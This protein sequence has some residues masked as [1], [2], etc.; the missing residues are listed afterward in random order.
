MRNL[1]VLFLVTVVVT[2]AVANSINMEREDPLTPP[3]ERED[4]ATPPME[5]EDPATPPMEREDPVTPPMEVESDGQMKLDDPLTPPPPSDEDESEAA[6]PDW[7]SWAGA[8]EGDMM[9]T[10]EQMRQ[11]NDSSAERN[12]I[13]GTRY[14]WPNGVIPYKFDSTTFSTTDKAKIAQ[15]FAK[16]AA[17]TCLRMVP[18][19][20]QSNYVSIIRDSGC[21]SYVGRIGGGQKLSLGYGCV[22]ERIIIHEFM[23]AAGFFHE[24]SR[25][26]RDTYVRI[27]YANIRDGY[28]NNFNKYSSSQIQHLGEPYD[29]TS[30]MHYSATAFSKNG[31]NTI[32]RLDGSTAALG[33][34]VGFSQVD[35]NKLNKLYSCSGTVTTT[36]TAPTTTASCIDRYRSCSYWSRYYCTGRFEAF[37]TRYCP[38]SC[39]KCGCSDNARY[40][41]RCPYWARYYCTGRYESFMTRYCAKSCNK[42]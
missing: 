14:L 32:D 4:P 19:T 27:N 42:C 10:E 22:Y 8:H 31:Q 13:R 16:Y 34:R 6:D 23:H 7:M 30:V 36:T 40:A 5:R 28:S 12:A 29:Y 15:A 41:T 25:Y 11:L 1:A 38:R 9:L 20:T 17:R 33:N 2:G 39:N 3:M 26:D 18:R 37:M 21:Y 35:V 24:Q